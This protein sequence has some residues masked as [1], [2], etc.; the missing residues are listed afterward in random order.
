M[1][2]KALLVSLFLVVL[3]KAQLTTSAHSRCETVSIPFCKRLG[4]NQTIFPNNL[5]H[6]NHE[7]AMADASEFK[8]LVESECSKDIVYFLCSLYSPVCTQM[9]SALPPCK[10][11]C[12][13]ARNGCE[14]LMNNYG[15]R[16]PDR[17]NCNR[18]PTSNEKLCVGRNTANNTEDGS[19]KK[20]FKR[21]G[22]T[23]I[24]KV[25]LS[26]AIIFLL[27]V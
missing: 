16:W 21:S 5:D 10:S 15:F 11:L 23:V 8:S 25:L 20:T 17:F 3:T 18:F 1:S 12:K 26:F 2:H 14:Q 22:M 9:G 24:C 27:R 19:S 7:E 13:S 4:Y 6:E